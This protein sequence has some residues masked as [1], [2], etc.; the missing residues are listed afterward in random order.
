MSEKSSYLRF[1][2]SALW[3]SEPDLPEFSL[4]AALRIFEKILTGIDDGLPIEHLAADGSVRRHEAIADVVGRLHR[5]FDPWTAP[6]EFLPWLASWLALELP[7]SW[8]EYQ[9]RR[10]ISSI[11]AIYRRRG[12]QRGLDENLGLHAVSDTMPRI[13]VDDGARL[14]TALPEAGRAVSID[15]LVADGPFSRPDDSLVY[16]GLVRPQCLAL[17]PGGELVVGDAGTP[18]Y[19]RTTVPEAV[20]LVPPEPAG[21]GEGPPPHPR[22]LG[23]QPWFPANPGVPVFPRAVA[24]DGGAP[25][26]VY[27]LDGVA[28]PGETAL[29]RLPSPDF[30]PVVAVATKAQLGVASPVAMAFDAAGHLLVLDRGAGGVAPKL[31]DVELAPFTVTPHPLTQVLSPMSLTVLA[32]GPGGGDV[33]VGDGREQVLPTPADLVQV[34]RGGPVWSETRLLGAVPAADNPLVAPTGLAAAGAGALLV[35][36]AGLKPLVPD[37]GDPY[38]REIAGPA[39]I[40]RVDLTQTPPAVSRA[41]EPNRLVSPRGMVSDGARV[42]I[43]DPGEPETGATQPRVTRA[44]P[45]EFA[46]VVH[47]DRRRPV[48]PL[49]RRTILGGISDIVGRSVPAHSLWTLV[50]SP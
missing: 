36:D 19:W 15:V 48:T 3:Q 10:V 23:P 45:H 2:P 50:S 20:W 46:V 38:T 27:V 1:L 29:Y 25:W 31:V 5:L 24:V 4:G 6:A 40:Y 41:S 39:A 30:A 28:L 34:R 22:R 11:V 12:L 49:E 44:L 33:V 7:P 35:L 18:T 32:T 8:D 26:Q 16:A 43:C 47:F 37:P 9:R 14:L 17:T 13:V 21:G 42:F